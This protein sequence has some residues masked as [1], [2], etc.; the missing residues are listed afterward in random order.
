MLLSYYKFLRN[1]VQHIMNAKITVSGLTFQQDRFDFKYF[2]DT[3]GIFKER[4]ELSL[5]H[6][7]G[8]IKQCLR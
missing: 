1:I 7:Y 5:H 3:Y 2:R 6:G 8:K 4:G